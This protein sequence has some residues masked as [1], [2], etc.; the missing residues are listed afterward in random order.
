MSG[1]DAPYQWIHTVDY[2]DFD[3]QVLDASHER[4]ILVDLWAEWCSPCVVIAPVLERVTPSVVNV[5]TQTRVR[6]RSPLLD[7][8]FF[9][10]FFNVPDRARERVSQSLGSGVIVDADKGYVL[11]NNHVIAGADDISVTLSDGRSFDA[12]VIGTDPD[13]DLAMVRIPA[14]V[15][16]K[17]GRASCRERV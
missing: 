4:P 2:E 11:T 1:K 14:E 9:R 15:A 7:D 10:R 12:E 16:A 6:V 3:R 17:I 8:P 5:Y 13:T